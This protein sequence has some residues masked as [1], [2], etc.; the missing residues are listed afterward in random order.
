M[1]YT[2]S[3][4]RLIKIH[5]RD[6][7]ALLH[8]QTT[9]DVKGLGEGVGVPGALCTP[10]GRMVANF[11]MALHD[12]AAWISLPEDRIDPLQEALAKFLPFFGCQLDVTDW[13][14]L[15]DRQPIDAPIQM[16]IG[17]LY[18]GWA[19][20]DQTGDAGWAALRI[21]QAL[22]W[23]DQHS[24]EAFTPQQLHLQTL[25]GISFTKGCYTG[26]EVIARTEH[27]GA[28][29]KSLIP[30]T[31]S[32]ETEICDLFVESRK[33]G[34]LINVSGTQGL[35]VIAA[36]TGPC[37]T[38]SGAQALPGALPYPIISPIKSRRNQS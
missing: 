4:W 26:Q 25:N 33:V 11:G 9:V 18:E 31:L 34:R 28:V 14:G 23:V 24:H 30:V 13:K 6:P 15:G 22:G 16:D 7:L 8:G 2:L 36:D 35:A 29:K 5:G 20:E 10:K 21:E 17:G 3:P 1:A 12:G 37:Q 38:E 19:P 27:L 32:T